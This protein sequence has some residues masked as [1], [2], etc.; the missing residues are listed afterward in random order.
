MAKSVEELDANDAEAALAFWKQEYAAGRASLDLGAMLMQ[1]QETAE[2]H[3]AFDAGVREFMAGKD[4][5]T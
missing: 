2:S 4:P 5:V 3:A 1:M